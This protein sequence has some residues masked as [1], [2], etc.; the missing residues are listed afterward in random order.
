MNVNK[1][2][3]NY[4]KMRSDRTT[5]DSLWQDVSNYVLPTRDFLVTRMDGQRRRDRLFDITAVED[6]KKLASTLH[7][8]MTSGTVRWFNLKLNDT[9][10]SADREVRVWLDDATRKMYDVFSSPRT[11]FSQQAYEMYL[12]CC[13]FG[14]GVMYIDRNR[15]GDF[16]FRYRK[17][18]DCFV[19]ENDDGRIDTLYRCNDMR[20]DEAIELWPDTISEKTKKLAKDN[21]NAIVKILHCVEPRRAQSYSRKTT[22][23]RFAQYYIELESKTLLEE[24]GFDMFPYVAPRFSKRDGETYGWGPGCDALPVARM[25]NSMFETMLRSAQKLADPPV[26][27]DDDA[28]I[29]PL[30]LDPASIIVTRNGSRLPTP[31]ITNNNPAIGVQHIEIIKQ[32]IHEIFYVDQLALPINDRMTQLEVS[33]RQQTQYRQLGPM[34]SRMQSEFLG[35]LIDRVFFMMLDANLFLPL[36]RQLSGQEIMVEYISTIAQAQRSIEADGILQ[37]LG[38]VAQIA[39]FD[40]NAIQNI[41]ADTLTRTI[42]DIYNYPAVALRPIE[43]VQAARDQATKAA[44]AQAQAQQAALIGKA[45][46]GM[47]SAVN[48]VA[49]AGNA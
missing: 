35:P 15:D 42:A 46:S 1:I 21:P 34:L 41:D 26:M 5:T 32:Q 36:P 13:A 3:S 30:K 7:S 33:S 43:Q 38:V 47:G 11:M 44:E 19:R 20:A 18:R 48:Q 16:R 39:Q 24:G 25:L 49:Q 2:I 4:Q 45:A 6:N 27:V 29:R 28:L 37:T 9:A 10:L 12:D 40:Q 14:M 23:K 31:L 22:K 17:L 8:L